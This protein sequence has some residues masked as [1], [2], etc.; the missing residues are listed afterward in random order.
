MDGE[1]E[2]AQSRNERS[3]DFDGE[4]IIHVG[5]HKTGTTTIQRYLSENKDKLERAGILYPDAGRGWGVNAPEQH[6]HFGRAIVEGDNS[7]LA[8][9]VEELEVEYRSAGVRKILLSTE[10]L[11][12]NNATPNKLETITRL[13]PNATRRWI[14][15]LRRTDDLMKSL[16]SEQLKKGLISFPSDYREIDQPILLD[17]ISRLQRVL[18]SRC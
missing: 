13:F 3:C 16:Y 15:L 9:F 1:P 2:I 17:H 12:R 10:V 7:Y 14:V 18:R 11:S 6:W 8:R 4:L 5:P